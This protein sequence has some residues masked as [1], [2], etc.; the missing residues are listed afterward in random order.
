MQA[1]R[2]KAGAGVCL[3]RTE[4]KE[5]QGNPFGNLK[6][7]VATLK[8]HKNLSSLTLRQPPCVLPI[9]SSEKASCSALRRI[10]DYQYKEHLPVFNVAPVSSPCDLRREGSWQTL[11]HFKR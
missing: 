11:L 3:P 8:T 2:R 9:P 6:V 5:R 1:L 10:C 7:E 4:L